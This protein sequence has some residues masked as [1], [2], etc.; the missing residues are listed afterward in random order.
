MTDSDGL[1]AQVLKIALEAGVAV[2]EVYGS[3][4]SSTEKE[5]RSPLTE[6]D[7]RSNETITRGLSTIDSTPILSEES[8]QIP[9]EERRNWTRFW[10]VD[11]LDGTKEFIKRNGEF[12]VNIA[13]IEE[14]APVLAVVHAP[15]ISVTYWAAGGKAYKRDAGGERV[16]S[17]EDYPGGTLRVVASRSHAGPETEALLESMK[18]EVVELDLL[19]IGSSLKL[20]MVADG[21]AHVYPRLGPTMEWDVAAADAVVRAAGGEVVSLDG[22]PLVY[23]KES[24]LNPFFIVRPRSQA[25]RELTSHALV[26]RA[27]QP[28]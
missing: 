28:A 7:L 4:F 3:E 2:M 13:L 16:I 19:S 5:D 14:G 9:F 11:P 21:Q 15:A 6:A 1:T 24:L 27:E 10:L 12:T 22:I 8:A 18:A 20:C 25:I 17:V 26:S 23:N